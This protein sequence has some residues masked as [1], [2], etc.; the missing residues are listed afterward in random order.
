MDNVS[1]IPQPE[2]GQRISFGIE[3]GGVWR[4]LGWIRAGK[5]GSVYVGN[6][7]GKPT[8]A[9]SGRKP[10][11]KLTT[12]NYSEI[13]EIEV[14]KSSP[15]SFHPSGELHIARERRSRCIG[16]STA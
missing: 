7:I 5:D 2:I 12:I 16:G 14:P 15:C 13:K 9:K 8:S 3:Y 11:E 10:M 1:G 6:L 4:P